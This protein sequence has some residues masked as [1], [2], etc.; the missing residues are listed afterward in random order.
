MEK[1]EERRETGEMTNPKDPL[2]PER[3]PYLK[4]CGRFPGTTDR[5]SQNEITT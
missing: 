3:R 1:T 4:M 5:Q 2:L